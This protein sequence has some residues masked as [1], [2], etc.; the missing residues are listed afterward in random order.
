MAGDNEGPRSSSLPGR[1]SFRGTGK[2]A[3]RPELFG[4]AARRQSLVVA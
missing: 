2:N 3:L 1:L 4:K